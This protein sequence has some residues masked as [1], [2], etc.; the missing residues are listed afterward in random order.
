M[1]ESFGLVAALA[2]GA[3]KPSRRLAP[4]EPF[5]TLAISLAPLANLAVNHG[6]LGTLHEAALV[7]PRLTL[8]TSLDALCASGTVLR[9]ARHLFPPRTPEPDGWRTLV[10]FL[11]ALDARTVAPVPAMVTA[12]LR[13]LAAAGYALDFVR[14]VRCGTGCPESRPAFVDPYLGGLICRACGGTGQTFGPELRRAAQAASVSGHALSVEHA[15][16]LLA[17]VD[18]ALAAHAGV[19]K[20]AKQPV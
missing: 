5:H 4:L 8:V 1:T 9:W 13:L 12:G 15:G 10:D 20:S 2:R 14:C 18:K 3:R 11:D 16:V 17:F 7:C 6:D 19:A